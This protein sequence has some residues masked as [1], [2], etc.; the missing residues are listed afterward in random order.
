LLAWI[1]GEDAG[2]LLASDSSRVAAIAILVA[3]FALF[4][5]WRRARVSQ[6]NNKL[7]DAVVSQ[8]KTDQRPSAEAMQLRERFDEALATLKAQKKRGGPG[9]YELPWYVIIGA[10]GSGKTTALRYSGLKFPLEQRS[11]RGALR[12]VGGT[13]NCD[14][15]FTEEAVLLDTAGRYTT[16]DSDASADSAGW[17]EFLG[18][19]KK[20]RKRRPLNGV[21]LAISAHDLITQGQAGREAHV[22]ATRRRLNELN[23]ELGIQLPVYVLVTKCDLLAG[24]AEYF[25]DMSQEERAQVFGVTFSQ[26]L[27]RAG[28]AAA[29]LPQEF[30]TLVGRLNQRVFSRLKDERDV[31]RRALI[32]GFPQQMAA[33]REGLSDFIAEV[34]ESTRF[35]QH[36][37]LRGVYLTSGTQEG[38]PID[39]LLGALGRRLALSTESAVPGKGKSYFIERAIKQVVLP[40]SGLASVS[41]RLE[42]QMAMTQFGL[43]A[44][45]IAAGA[46]VV[47][48]MTYSYRNNRNFLNDFKARV[49]R[50][51]QTIPEAGDTALKALPR[52]NAL[53]SLAAAAS[54]HRARTWWVSRGWGLDQSHWVEQNV[55]SIYAGESAQSLVGTVKAR[56]ERRLE[57]FIGSDASSLDL[58]STLRAYIML[59]D[60]AHYNRDEV[61]NTALREWEALYPGHDT[62][63]Q[64]LDGHF[65]ELLKIGLPARSIN[66]KLV[67]RARKA[68]PEG[69]TPKLILAWLV[70]EYDKSNK[71]DPAVFEDPAMR[72]R[73]GRP[74]GEGLSR[75]FTQRGF[76]A[77]QG[78]IEGAENRFRNED[79][80]W[81]GEGAKSREGTNEKVR[82]L[83]EKEYIRQW[84]LVLA[85]VG[86]APAV[87]DTA[88]I[89]L[90]E[91]VA[92]E[93]TGLKAVLQ[94]VDRN[95][96]LVTPAGTGPPPTMLGGA[97]DWVARYAT[98]ARLS[99]QGRTVNLGTEITTHFAEIHALVTPADGKM[100]VM[101]ELVTKMKEMKAKLELSRPGQVGGGPSG[102]AAMELAQ[103]AK[104]LEHDAKN[105]SG[106]AADIGTLL[107]DL[108]RSTQEASGG[109]LQK[110]IVN[111]FQAVLKECRQKTSGY[112][113]YPS[114]KNDVGI[115]DFRDLFG[116]SGTFAK[117]SSDS[118]KG[119][120]QG[121]PGE[122]V[123]LKLSGGT[124]NIDS[125]VET[126]NRAA[127]ITAAFFPSGQPEFKFSVLPQQL[128]GVI[129]FEL[130]ENVFD[131]GSLNYQGQSPKAKNGIWPAREGMTTA[132]FKIDNAGR[133]QRVASAEGPWAW[134]RLID[135]GV[136]KEDNDLTYELT[137]GNSD[138]RVTLRLKAEARS[139]PIALIKRG[140][141]SDFASRCGG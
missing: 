18:L 124:L 31:R 19:L 117:F 91:K 14:W 28:K 7:A 138:S 32:F 95:T 81:K 80:V 36:V 97:V 35:D 88:I 127:R 37:L 87:G 55:K 119:Y 85:N 103:K 109:Q 112:P 29:A 17:A 113:F 9:L 101:D 128:D 62:Y 114:S 20:Y 53:G 134:F 116:P 21:L 133:T 118:L 126:L 60:K 66:E 74:L 139:N 5:M 64:A 110:S 115:G 23:K 4:E 76:K 102:P 40:E 136:L 129:G 98:W 25:E 83:Y 63:I 39:R 72:D 49:V 33:L 45:M 41:R 131:S 99:L 42:I 105:L 68:I 61:R 56:M 111:E 137:L 77:V 121:P 47:G 120:V 69:E 2:A 78:L 125:I 75:I 67:E 27:S 108:S 73:R 122:L 50:E 46:I 79:W 65:S 51:S 11:G 93:N 86:F 34:F 13:R 89:A 3:L 15:W 10:P 52:L 58:Y 130:D 44:G 107:A 43:Y 140:F 106:S 70:G 94:V 30:D 100:A 71:A 38:T 6:A 135:Q 24:F 104:D 141:M 48:M 59:T 90:I 1:F 132:R 26:D 96:F 54:E 92:N 8:A 57:S 22:A 16:Q 12:G 84:D 82:Q 123:A